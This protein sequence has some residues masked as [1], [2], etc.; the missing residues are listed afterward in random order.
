MG[1]R[2]IYI[3]VTIL[4]IYAFTLFMLI[5]KNAQTEKKM[6]APEN[7]QRESLVST[8]KDDEES[9]ID[10]YEVIV[11]NEFSVRNSKDMHMPSMITSN[12][13]CSK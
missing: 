9:D 12:N 4:F 5:C 2:L 3:N 11:Q 7:N 6:I 8:Q 13:E 1:Q 10:N